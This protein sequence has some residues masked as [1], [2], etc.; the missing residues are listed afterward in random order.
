[1]PQEVPPQAQAALTQLA[2]AA[3]L[4]GRPGV[5]VVE[6]DLTVVEAMVRSRTR[7]HQL[8]QELESH[9][10]LRSVRRGVY[11]LVSQTGT[12]EAGLLDLIAAITPTPYIVTAGR[13]LQFHELSDQHFRLVVVAAPRKLHSWAWRGDTV[14]YARVGRHRLRGSVI[15]T[16]R[17]A[18]R[19]ASPERAILDSL[20]HPAWGVSLSQVVEALDVAVRRNDDF[21][22]RLAAEA[23][24]AQ[25]N[26]VARRLGFLVSRV[27]G[28]PDARAFLALRGSSKAITP[29]QAGGAQTGRIDRM[30]RVRENVEF[31]QLLGHREVM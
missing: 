26:A 28:D 1:M 22:D 4:A 3:S 15:R 14:R 25:N 31:E 27:V 21:V 12:I 17:T 23:A 8:L 24:L 29:L 2:R 7:A 19:V 9:G 16:R 30:W 6:E 18:A 5:V 13:A 20:E 11:T 10:R